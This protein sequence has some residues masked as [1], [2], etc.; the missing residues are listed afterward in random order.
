MRLE[1]NYKDS[2]GKSSKSFN[3]ALEGNEIEND[4]LRME[5]KS[6]IRT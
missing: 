5:M 6:V 4:T 3:K 1:E 2:Y